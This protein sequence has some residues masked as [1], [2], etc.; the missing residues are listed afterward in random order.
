MTDA[1]VHQFADL[2][3]CGARAESGRL[4]TAIRANLNQLNYKQ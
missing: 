3:A 1:A 2:S 4:E